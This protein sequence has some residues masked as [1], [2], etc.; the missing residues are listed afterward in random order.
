MRVTSFD[1]LHFSRLGSMSDAH[2]NKD[3]VMNSLGEKFI[4][5]SKTLKDIYR[6]EEAGR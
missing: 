5:I 6:V 2:L 4:A 1:V 3:K